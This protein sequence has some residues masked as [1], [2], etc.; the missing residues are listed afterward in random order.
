MVELALV[1]QMYFDPRYR[2]SRLAK[3]V[4]PL[5]LAA[6][7][8]DYFVFNLWL[9]IP[10]FSPIVERIIIVA[11]T[12]FTY[13]VLALELDRYRVVLDYLARHSSGR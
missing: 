2:I 12:V 9:V 4:L 5:V 11:L 6:L 10:V 13:R 8:A 7:V 1:A 3:I